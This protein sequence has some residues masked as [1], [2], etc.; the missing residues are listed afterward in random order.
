MTGATPE[1]IDAAIVGGGVVGLAAA[2]AVAARG[3]ATCVVE[4]LPRPGLEAST[5][6]SGVVH[7]GIYYPRDSLKAVLC[8]ETR[9]AVRLLRGARGAVRALRQARRR[10]RRDR[11]QP[12]LVQAAGIDSPGLTASL[13]IAERVADLV[14]ETLAWL[15]HILAA[16]SHRPGLLPEHPG[17]G[18]C[19][20]IALDDRPR[21]MVASEDGVRA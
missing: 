21:P 2:C 11:R 18:P 19:Q 5:H 17:V 8:V 4:R 20:V 10:L 6:N 9:A 7:A 12:R 3:H 1:P 14:N 13:A 15:H 16:F